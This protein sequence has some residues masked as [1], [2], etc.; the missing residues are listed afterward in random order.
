MSLPAAPRGP[1]VFLIDPSRPA[2]AAMAATAET[3]G[4]SQAR[5]HTATT[6]QNARSRPP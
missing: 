4:A 3:G 5:P 1:G 2:A 6:P